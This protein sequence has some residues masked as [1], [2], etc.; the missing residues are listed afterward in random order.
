M[1]QPAHR[2]ARRLGAL[3]SAATGT[4][5]RGRREVGG[6]ARREV[7][8]D[9]VYGA[10]LALAVR[11]AAVEAE[12]VR[13]LHCGVPIRAWNRWWIHVGAGG[14]FQCRGEH[15]MLHDDRYA[16]PSRQPVSS[17][18]AVGT[19]PR[20]VLEAASLRGGV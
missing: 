20:T 7:A 13:C 2:I 10:P 17:P 8:G 4:R 18:T 12:A 9:P 16:V 11:R 6:G 1:P 3:W 14:T 5:S 19:C 15:G